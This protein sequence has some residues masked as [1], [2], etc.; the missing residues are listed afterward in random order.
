MI[1]FSYWN[2][3]HQDAGNTCWFLLSVFQ[4]LSTYEQIR[5]HKDT[6]ALGYAGFLPLTLSEKNLISYVVLQNSLMTETHLQHLQKFLYFSA[7]CLAYLSLA[8]IFLSKGV[9]REKG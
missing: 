3:Y 6:R 4:M 1:L 9:E 7:N 8:I 2:C 5:A